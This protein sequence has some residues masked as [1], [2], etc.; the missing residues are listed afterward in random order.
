[1]KEGYIINSGKYFLTDGEQQ[2]YAMTAE[3]KKEIFA[4]GY[5]WSINHRN[6]TVWIG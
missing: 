1:M 6:K 4:A 3:H 2:Y 5:T